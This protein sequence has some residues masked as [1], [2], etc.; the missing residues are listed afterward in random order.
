[1]TAITVKNLSNGQLAGTIGDLYTAP[2]L[3]TTII[4]SITLVNTHTAELS[5]NLY[6]LKSGGTAR[7]IIPSNMTLGIGYLLVY[8]DVL[9]LGAG[10]KIQGDAGTAAKVDYVI[11]GVEEA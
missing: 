11:S 1:M 9:T 5:V 10:D 6:V 7:K 4:K 2:A 3:T 8:D